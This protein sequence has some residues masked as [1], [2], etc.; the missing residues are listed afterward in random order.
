MPDDMWVDGFGS[1]IGLFYLC[2]SAVLA[3]NV[4]DAEA[5]DGS[6]IGVKEDSLCA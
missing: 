4:T 6:A 2:L 3:G 1:H 5:S